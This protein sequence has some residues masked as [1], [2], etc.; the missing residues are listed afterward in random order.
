MNSPVLQSL[1]AVYYTYTEREKAETTMTKSSTSEEE[2]NMLHDALNKTRKQHANAAQYIHDMRTPL[3]TIRCIIDGNLKHH[4]ALIR[5]YQLACDNELIQN[6][7]RNKTLRSLEDALNK[8][9]EQVT[10]CNDSLNQILKLLL[11]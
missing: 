10:T 3:L 7:L 9:P 1:F 2:M 11:D 8:I 6:P 5:G 4:E